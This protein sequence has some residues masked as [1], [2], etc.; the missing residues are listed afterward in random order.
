MSGA[1][2]AV[3]D[4]SEELFVQPAGLSLM[5][6]PEVTLGYGRMYLGLSDGSN[7]SDNLASLGFKIGS[8]T[9]CGFAYKSTA[10]DSVYT[11][12]SYMAAFAYRIK[13]KVAIGVTGKYLQLKYGNDAYTAIDPVFSQ[14][15]GKSNFDL[16]AGVI[17]SLSDFINVSYARQNNLGADMGIAGQ[18]LLTPVDRLGIGY[19]EDGFCISIEDSESPGQSNIYS[20][21]EKYI[22]RKMFAIRS[23]AAFSNGKFAK[24]S[25]GLG[26][27]MGD[28]RFDY[29]FDMPLA[30]IVN[31]QGTHFM[32]MSAKIFGKG[33]KAVPKIVEY[34]G[35]DKKEAVI[36][37]AKVPQEPIYIY[38]Y[39]PVSNSQVVASSG[40]FAVPASSS[41]ASGV[42]PE[43]VQPK[44]KAAKPAGEYIPPFVKSHKVGHGETLPDIA[45]KYYGTKSG[46]TKIFN[47]NK[48]K[49]EKGCVKEGDILVIP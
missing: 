21:I 26:I 24:F 22:F 3:S 12:Q 19:L 45:L 39:P 5:T 18:Y 1:I 23:G 36:N 37:K 41:S 43:T 14:S 2:S 28:F 10:L 46:W 35:E 11:E 34:K 44:K 29:S 49:I 25:A 48:D 15:Y 30:G 40:A 16:D 31:T 33:R 9:G 42:I 20:G 7:I 32:T 38:V 47:A 6:G 4:N 13:H 17:V 27:C 8:N